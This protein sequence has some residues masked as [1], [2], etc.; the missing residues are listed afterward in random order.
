MNTDAEQGQAWLAAFVQALQ[1]LGWQLGGDVQVDTRWGAGNT[2]LFRK[3]AAELVASGRWLSQLKKA[4]K[5]G[6]VVLV[7]YK[8][9]K[10]PLKAVSRLAYRLANG[11]SW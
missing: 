8:N 3:Y 1:Q 2:E 4:A 9:Q 11:I 5:S 7:I 10:L 6:S